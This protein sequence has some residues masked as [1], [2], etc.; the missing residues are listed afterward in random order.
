MPIQI[1][2]K[3]V[4]FNFDNFLFESIREKAFGKICAERNQDFSRAEGKVV[5]TFFYRSTN[6]TFGALPEHLKKLRNFASQ[7]IFERKRNKK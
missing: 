1:L 2:G 7:A 3:L 6:L 5:Y 4:V